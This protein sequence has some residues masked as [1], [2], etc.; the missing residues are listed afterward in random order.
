MDRVAFHTISM[1]ARGLLLSLSSDV[2][3]VFDGHLGSELSTTIDTTESH[4]FE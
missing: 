1:L 3:I 2:F 4:R